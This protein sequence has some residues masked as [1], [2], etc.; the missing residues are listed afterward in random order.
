M[1]L[2]SENETTTGKI[3]KI[4]ETGPRVFSKQTLIDKGYPYEP[5]QN[6]YLVYKVEIITDEE[7][8]NTNWDITELD[9]YKKGRGSALPFSATMT[10]LMKVKKK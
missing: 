5:S 9:G 8:K 2:H 10:E 7:F 4:T 3:L 1:L 6:Y